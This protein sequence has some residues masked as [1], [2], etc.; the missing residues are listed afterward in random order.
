MGIIGSQ[1]PDMPAALAVA[2]LFVGP[3]LSCEDRVWLMIET[4]QLST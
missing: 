2:L 3:W 1:H 4:R